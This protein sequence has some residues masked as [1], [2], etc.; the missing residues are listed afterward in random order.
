MKRE[1]ARRPP[2]PEQRHHTR[3]QG[4]TLQGQDESKLVQP[5]YEEE[6]LEIPTFLRRQAN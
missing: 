5:S 2:E 4:E 6:Q 1:P 3:M